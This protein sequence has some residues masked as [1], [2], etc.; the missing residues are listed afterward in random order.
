[1]T[2]T[3]FDQHDVEVIMGIIGSIDEFAHAC[4]KGKLKAGNNKCN[5]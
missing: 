3:L 5:R 1:M 2:Q 4:M